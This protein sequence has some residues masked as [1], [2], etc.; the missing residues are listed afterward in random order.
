[1][2][3]LNQI[4][5]AE[6]GQ[7]SRIN[8]DVT[9]VYHNL[10]KPALYGGFSKTYK[11]RD[12]EGDRYPDEG[13]VVQRH[14]A[15]DLNLVATKL[16][17]LIDV[18]LTKDVANTQARGSIRLPGED[19]PFLTAPVPFLLFLEKQLVDFRTMISKVPTLDPSEVWELDYDTALYRTQ[20]V[21]SFKTKKVPQVLVK[22]PATDRH[23][24]QTEVF[25]SDEIVGEWTTTKLSGAMSRARRDELL[26]RV[27]VFIDAVKH[28][29]EEANRH[30]VT[31]QTAGKFVFDRLLA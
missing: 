27:N 9:A 14:V 21:G 1:L 15:D 3:Q 12:E 20:P 29:V 4:V 18:T 17:Q 22:Y 5:A 25:T 28:A 24:A 6:K 30:E 10:Q 7:K 13:V 8:N 26:E 11:P 19:T 23:P 16:S 2:T 31:Q